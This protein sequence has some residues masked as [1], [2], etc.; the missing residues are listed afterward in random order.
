MKTLK[1]FRFVFDKKIVLVL[2]QKSPEKKEKIK[3]K[4]HGLQKKKKNYCNV[5]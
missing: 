2:N 1:L 3:L 4:H 5:F